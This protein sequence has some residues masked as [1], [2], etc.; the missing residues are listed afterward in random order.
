MTPPGT[1]VAESAAVTPSGRTTAITAITAADR[2]KGASPSSRPHHRPTTVSPGSQ[3][4]GERIMSAD[5]LHCGVDDVGPVE[6]GHVV[7]AVARAGDVGRVPAVAGHRRPSRLPVEDTDR[8][9]RLGGVLH[10]GEG[11]ALARP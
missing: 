5:P 9:T 4:A 7:P 3:R 10:G 2:L 8:A 6:H 1:V 11:R